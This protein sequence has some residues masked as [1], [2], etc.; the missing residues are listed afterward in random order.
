[1]IRSLRAEEISCEGR[2]ER[3][4]LA[5]LLANEMTMGPLLEFPESA[6]V[7]GREGAKEREL[8]WERGIDKAG[9]EMLEN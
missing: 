2:S 4:R 1:M 5:E 6:E 9:E 3:K 8:K 7:G